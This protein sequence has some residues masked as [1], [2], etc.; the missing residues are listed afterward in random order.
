MNCTAIKYLHTYNL[1]Y[2]HI[3]PVS[4]VKSLLFF[5]RGT[6]GD[7]GVRVHDAAA[8]FKYYNIP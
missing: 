2:I 3:T 1:H 4:R 8:V 5:N 6:S 7:G